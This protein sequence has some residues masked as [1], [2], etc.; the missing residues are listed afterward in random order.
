MLLKTVLAKDTESGLTNAAGPD[1]DP[2]PDRSSSKEEYIH[3]VRR[4]LSEQPGSAASSRG[5]RGNG[6]DSVGRD[7]RTT[8]SKRDGDLLGEV[9][10]EEGRGEF[11]FPSS[12]DDTTQSNTDT[13]DNG[14]SSTAGLST[15]YFQLQTNR[16]C[17]D[18]ENWQTTNGV[19]VLLKTCNSA[20]W[21]Q[22]WS[23]DSY[24]RLKNRHASNKCLEAG[25]DGIIYKK[26]FIWDCHQGTHQRWDKL[27]NGKYKNKEH[28]K[29]LGVAYCG[30]RSKTG[31][32]ELRNLDKSGVCNCAQ[33]WNRISSVCSDQNWEEFT[34][35]IANVRSE[36]AWFSEEDGNSQ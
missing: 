29:Y 11:F 8:T 17:A 2:D 5:V 3:H 6:R 31:Y 19:K 20:A 16:L 24:G 15:S 34:D 35:D 13:K 23:Y 28:D 1:P 33:T 25:G 18:L 21:S 36:S 30:D 4:V 26:A 10:G 27:S 7:N 9:L 32:L 14:V 22:Q 12:G